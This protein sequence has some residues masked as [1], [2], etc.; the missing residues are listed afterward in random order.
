[1]YSSN[2]CV[3]SGPDE[4]EIGSALAGEKPK[5]AE[6]TVILLAYQTLAFQ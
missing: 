6:V 1:V 4:K 2:N 5:K 3:F